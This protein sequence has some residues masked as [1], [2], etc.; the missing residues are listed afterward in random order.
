[1]SGR[2]TVAGDAQ[3]IAADGVDGD[4]ED[5]PLPGVLAR[6]DRRQRLAAGGGGLC[7]GGDRSGVSPFAVLIDPVAGDVFRTRI[8]VGPGIVAVAAAEAS[9]EAITVVVA[10]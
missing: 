4:D 6:L 8:N 9:G 5:V 10:Q 1:M 7:R 2:P 3:P